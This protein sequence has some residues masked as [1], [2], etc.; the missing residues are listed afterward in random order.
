M[1]DLD[2]VWIRPVGA[3]PSRSGHIFATMHAKRDT[4][5][6]RA[7]DARYWKLNFVRTPD[8]R[9]HFANSPMAFPCGSQVL[10]SSLVAFRKLLLEK[11]DLSRLH[12]SAII[13][14]VLDCIHDRGLALDVV[15]P[16]IFHPM[17]HFALACHVFGKASTSSASA[18]SVQGVSLP[19]TDIVM[20]E[21]STVSQ[22]WFSCSKSEG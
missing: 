22:T 2:Q 6:G 5:R 3:C 14:L 7:G 15:D 13:K 11:K 16:S 12:Y 4:H 18:E 21:S 8:E 1:G 20:K 10:D 17:P 19:S 9:I